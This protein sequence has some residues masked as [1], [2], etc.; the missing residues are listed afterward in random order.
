MKKILA[1]R[2]QKPNEVEE[3]E[4]RKKVRNPSLSLILWSLYTP[5]PTQK[6]ISNNNKIFTLFSLKS[7]NVINCVFVLF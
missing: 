4:E 5:T 6:N 2:K 3:E 7:L 1:I